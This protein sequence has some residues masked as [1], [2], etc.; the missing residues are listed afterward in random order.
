MCFLI[1]M[2]KNYIPY[3]TN[4]WSRGLNQ[5]IPFHL[6]VKL[7]ILQFIAAIATFNNNKSPEIVK[8]QLN[9]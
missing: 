9:L 1:S 5:M 7:E 4:G 6:S 2:P 3:I 8:S